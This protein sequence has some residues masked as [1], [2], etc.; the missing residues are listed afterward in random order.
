LSVGRIGSAVLEA[1]T[2]G[3]EGVDPE[4]FD[5]A[6]GLAVSADVEVVEPT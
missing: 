1:A 6:G 2:G 5:D 4:A 3:C